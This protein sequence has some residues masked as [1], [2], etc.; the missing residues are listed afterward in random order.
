MN[1]IKKVILKNINSIGYR[2]EKNEKNK[3]RTS[4]K[5]SINIIELIGPSGIGKTYF[6]D[7]LFKNH[8]KDFNP[9]A[10]ISPQSDLKNL[11]ETQ[12]PIHWK[13]FLSKTENLNNSSYPTAV[14][15]KLN[16]YFT[17]ILIQDI[18]LN[19][20]DKSYSFLLD[21]GI[22]HNFS[23]EIINLQEKELSSIL[24]GRLAVFLTSNDS[25]FIFEQIKKRKNE[26]GKIVVWHEHYDKNELLTK[27]DEELALHKSLIKKLQLNNINTIEI[28]A[29]LS[30]HEKADILNSEVEKII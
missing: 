28:D 26:T 11:A 6:A 15:L 14:K 20:I 10:S 18:N 3:L 1:P 5:K 4:S 19:N 21:E 29:K 7:Y 17:S 12:H 27:I 13:L 22:I 9:R 2:I 16:H 30:N 8:F 24:K 25:E 23:K